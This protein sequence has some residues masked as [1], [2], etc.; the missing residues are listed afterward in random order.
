MLNRRTFIK[1][2]TALAGGGLLLNHQLFASSLAMKPAGLQLF[3]LFNVIEKDVPGSIKKIAAIGYKEIE[4]AF[5]S[6]GAFYGY[7]AR[8]F[9][10]LLNDNGL[11]WKSHHVIGAPFKLPP[12]AKLPTGPD[13][14]PI[15]IPPMKNLRENMQELVDAVAEGG[16]PY[17]VCAN[18][19]YD[20]ADELTKSIETLNKT[21]AACKKAGMQFAYHN[22][23]GEFKTFEGKVP[24]DALLTD[25]EIPMEL[26]ICWTVKAGIDPVELF[27]KHPGRFHLWHVKDID[28]GFTGPQPVGTGIIDWKKIFDATAVSGMQHFFVEHDMPKDPFASITISME[29]LIKLIG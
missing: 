25:T 23:D 6:K 28:K 4:S 29:N 5:S 16:I 10:S 1:S 18:T 27:K 19:P 17:L 24:Y 26:D 9:N 13:G 14:K 3:T 7:S 20:T 15:N 21:A 8:E 22:H 11:S 2:T 12:G